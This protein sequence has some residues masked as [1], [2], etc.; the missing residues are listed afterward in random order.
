MATMYDSDYVYPM[1]PMNHLTY[2]EQLPLVRQWPFVEYPQTQTQE[3]PFYSDGIC[4]HLHPTSNGT[5]ILDLALSKQKQKIADNKANNMSKT[6]A[7]NKMT[8]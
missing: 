5:M 7:M 3:R 1:Y 6:T 8:K 2:E 4:P